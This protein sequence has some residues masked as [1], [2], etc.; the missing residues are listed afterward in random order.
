MIKVNL[1]F[2][3]EQ[4]I[5]PGKPYEFMFRSIPRTGE[6]VILSDIEKNDAFFPEFSKMKNNIFC[7]KEVCYSIISK[8]QHSIDIFLRESN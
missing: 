6:T 8:E 3:S 5:H 2:E 1:I 7:V 4:M